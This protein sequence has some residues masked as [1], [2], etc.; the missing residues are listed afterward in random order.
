MTSADLGPRTSD[1]RQSGAV[2]V[3]TRHHPTRPDPRLGPVVAIRDHVGCSGPELK[4]LGFMFRRVSG[5]RDRGGPG[6]RVP[7]V[8]IVPLS[9]W[10]ND[11]LLRAAVDYLFAINNG[12]P[13]HRALQAQQRLRELSSGQGS[14]ASGQ[15]EVVR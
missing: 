12:A 13:S 3:L 5:R 11:E 1:R 7:G 10:E 15:R 8:W 4:Q 9:R 14:V 6:K 2:A